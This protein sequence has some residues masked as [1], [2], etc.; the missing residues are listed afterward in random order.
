MK[1]I[2][3]S[4]GAVKIILPG[5]HFSFCTFGAYDIAAVL[6]NGA[7]IVRQNEKC[8]SRAFIDSQGSRT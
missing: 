7:P 1:I 2:Y 4:K 5:Q 8:C 3:D 6:V